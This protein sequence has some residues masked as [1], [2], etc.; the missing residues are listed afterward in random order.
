[1]KD[2][3][4]SMPKWYK[5]K[6][7]EYDETIK[8]S[9]QREYFRIHAYSKVVKKIVLEAYNNFSEGKIYGIY[10]FENG[11]FHKVGGVMPTFRLGGDSNSWSDE[12]EASFAYFELYTDHV[13]KY[14][15]YDETYKMV[16]DSRMNNAPNL[17]GKDVFDKSF[18]T[19]CDIVTNFLYF[20]Y[21]GVR[22]LIDG[23]YNVLAKFPKKLDV[24]KNA[25][26]GDNTKQFILKDGKK[27][28]LYDI[29]E[30][31]V[32]MDDIVAVSN[33][34]QCDF[35]LGNGDIYKYDKE[36][37]RFALLSKYDTFCDGLEKV[38]TYIYDIEQEKLDERDSRELIYVLKD[39]KGKFYIR[40]NNKVINKNCPFDQV[41][42]TREHF[43]FDKRL[44]CKVGDISDIYEG[45]DKF[46]FN[47]LD[48]DGDSAQERLWFDKD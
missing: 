25:F 7:D 32:V 28:C 15:E 42:M 26:V 39:D 38:K 23:D 47:T 3:T 8:R 12:R 24:R 11:V 19:V 4:V 18:R 17:S 27:W 31:K 46:K 6:I 16:I 2:L 36:S 34:S 9:L 35:R 48:I 10:D 29:E 37:G 13:N 14:G 40:Q 21:K 5:E 41:Y 45:N 33:S 1:M 20:E 22:Y 43:D 30:K 44:I